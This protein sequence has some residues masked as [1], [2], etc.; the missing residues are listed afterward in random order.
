MVYDVT[1]EIAT[2]TVDFGILP[3]AGMPF[4]DGEVVILQKPGNYGVKLSFTATPNEEQPFSPGQYVV[5]S[6]VCEGT[7]GS[8]HK[9]TETLSTKNANFTITG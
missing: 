2:G 7:C 3:P 6:A 5:Q 8:I 4:G 1:K 9:W